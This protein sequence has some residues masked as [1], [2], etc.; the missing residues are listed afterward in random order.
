MLEL[1]AVGWIVVLVCGFLVGLSK[2]GL[3]GAA[4]P[5]VVAL[6]YVLGPKASVGFILPVLIMGDIC[7]LAYYRR[8]AVWKI[9][10][11]LLP[12]AVAGILCGFFLLGR[13][14]DDFLKILIGVIVIVLLAVDYWRSRSGEDTGVPTRWWFAAV[15]GILA[16]LT[17]MLANAA[18]P[19]MI[20]YLAAMRISKEQY[21]GS[22][23]WYFFML[24]SF[25]VPFYISL[26]MITT[27]RFLTG[28]VL[29]P[30]VVAGAVT[31]IFVLKRIPQKG[32]IMF[33]KCVAF[34][35]AIKL[36]LPWPRQS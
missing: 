11:R 33:A 32:F 23:A 30:A 3:P 22:G 21:M 20:I 28:L 29:L 14:S 5:A 4:T 2:N 19:L 1:T 35:L 24:N 9:I 34:V 15:I 36:L 8:H 31:G 17:T 16:G 26:G 18:G 13:I 6:V 27:E 7:A 12:W 10:V 25:K